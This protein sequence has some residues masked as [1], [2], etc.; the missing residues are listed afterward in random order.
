MNMEEDV[1][2]K[3]ASLKAE[4][5]K[6][7]GFWRKFGWQ[8]HR[9]EDD[10]LRFTT[11]GFP[12]PSFKGGFKWVQG[13]LKAQSRMVSKRND[14]W[15]CQL[16]FLNQRWE[17]LQIGLCIPWLL[18]LYIHL[19]VPAPQW[20]MNRMKGG[21]EYELGIYHY[22]D[23]GW[24]YG[25]TWFSFFYDPVNDGYKPQRYGRRWYIDWHRLVKGK[26]DIDTKE[27]WAIHHIMHIPEMMGYPALDTYADIRME[28]ITHRYK[29]WWVP[30]RVFYRTE[31]EIAEGQPRPEHQG[32]G[33]NGWDCVMT[34][35][36]SVSFGGAFTH[37][38]AIIKFIE[39]VRKSRQR[40]G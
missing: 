8:S 31:V 13:E 11:V 23:R 5:Y 16:T 34:H 24:W 19:R 9:R 12:I 33:E 32:K 39:D 25:M 35:T 4:E 2:Q 1:K 29:R 3:D 15:C 7:R 27:E 40:Y 30:N 38:E 21:E 26:M 36:S 17:P 22:N 6:T 20:L 10:K 37:E 28:K 18:S 14:A